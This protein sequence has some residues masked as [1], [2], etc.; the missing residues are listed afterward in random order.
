MRP[1]GH[2]GGR[3]GACLTTSS[4][5]SECA[6]VLGRAATPSCVWG[7]GGVCLHVACWGSGSPRSPA[8]TVTE[9]DRAGHGCRG[10]GGRPKRSETQSH[11]ASTEMPTCVYPARICRLSLEQQS[12]WPIRTASA[13]QG[14]LG[15]KQCARRVA[16]GKGPAAGHARVQ[17]EL[18]VHGMQVR[19][20][21]S[22]GQ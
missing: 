20:V 10:R 19:R 17:G 15:A 5:L 8:Q 18:A 7:G 12:I 14:A 3:L 6:S 16:G 22:S 21:L 2:G 4:G 11:R 9:Q 13:R 1:P